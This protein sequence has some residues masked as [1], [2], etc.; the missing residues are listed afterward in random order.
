MVNLMSVSRIHMKRSEKSDSVHP[1]TGNLRVV[2]L[3]LITCFLTGCE[4]T[5]QVKLKGGTHPVFDL[6]GS[7]EVCSLTVFGP[8]FMTKAERPRDENFAVW[9]IEPSGGFNGTWIGKLGSITYGVVPEGYTQ[10]IPKEGTPVPLIDGQKYLYVVETIN[11]PGAS[12][13]FEIR[14]SKAVPTNGSGYPCFLDDHGKSIRIPCP[15]ILE[16]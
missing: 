13:Y 16:R 8:E 11:A 3:L 15:K 6:S 9:K 7:G 2:L 4:R 12:G 1:K 10:A 14:N 5:T